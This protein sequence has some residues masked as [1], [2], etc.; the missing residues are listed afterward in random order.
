MAQHAICTIFAKNY[1]SFV[2]VLADS[3]LAHHPHG[4]VYGLLCDR[5]DGYFDPAQ[6]R[7]ITIQLEELS[8]PELPE[9]IYKY[10]LVEL[11]TAVKAALLAYLFAHYS[12]DKL[13][14]FDPDILI[15][16][17]LQEIF[18]LLENHNIVLLPHLTEPQTG[19]WIPSEKQL[20]TLGTYNLG[21]IGLRKGPVTH[22]FLEWW[23]TKLMNDCYVDPARGLYVDQHW[24]DLVP[25]LFEKVYV[26]RDPGCN[27]AYWNLPERPIVR[28]GDT[29]WCQG[30][31]VKF[32]H[33]SGYSPHAP[34]R[35][36]KRVP[37]FGRRLSI[38]TLGAG[39]EL[40]D[41][42]RRLLIQHDFETT[43]RWPY[44]LGSFTNGVPVP[45]AARRLWK[46]ACAAGLHWPDPLDS[47]PPDSFYQW[48]LQPIDNGA[49][50]INRLADYVYRVRL[51]VQKAFP[52]QRG[53][54][55]RE[56]VRWY[57]ETGIQEHQIPE[58]FAQP[59][60]HSLAQTSSTLEKGAFRL[61]P[62]LKRLRAS[63]LGQR[64][65]RSSLAQRARRWLYPAPAVF[66]SAVSGSPPLSSNSHADR[67]P[68]LNVIG[69]LSA[70]TD[71]GAISRGIVHAL[72]AAKYPIAIIHLDHPD[73]ARR[74]DW[75]FLDL[76]QSTR[77]GVNLFGIDAT[78]CGAVT[79]LLSQEVLAHRT[80]IGF[81]LWEVAR[82]PETWQDRFDGLDEIWV[83]SAFVQEA[84]GTVSPIP[85]VKMGAPVV[86]RAPSALSRRDVRLPEDKFVFLYAFDMLSIPERKNPL[87]VVEA[88]RLAFEPNFQDTHLVVRANHL[89]RFPEWQERLRQ[90][91]AS[92]KGTLIEEKLDRPHVNALYHL[93]DAYVSLHR[94]EG[95]GLTIAEM[96]QMGK[97]VIATDYSGPRD[98]LNQSN[99]YPVRYRLIELDRDYGPY[100]AGNV[101]ADPD[102]EHAAE[103]MR[104]ILEHP[105][106][107]ARKAQQAAQDIERLY[108]TSAIA[109]RI[110]RRLDQIGASL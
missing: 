67:Q 91:V 56:F 95:F 46:E 37:E 68:G 12:L 22:R 90:A 21:F 36:S 3:F 73:G 57:V 41:L 32:F 19:E 5:L 20:L 49:P 78:E 74:D 18:D 93:A 31:P 98:F 89:H 34:R 2:R 33:F 15:L 55:R 88:Y 100:R 40:F 66:P 63:R 86:L 42:Y 16:S 29:Y 101:W 109:D 71:V 102:T 77:H 105:E 79:Q 69:H 39:A 13:C 25:G 9:I 104:R 80:N 35:I 103:L 44:A 27:I 24:V 84:V 94:S 61:Q 26:H 4:V 59:M 50:L 75:P 92:V 8:I 64:V 72:R 85:V 47:T 106:D 62:A 60:R 70:E 30:Q 54:H 43:S 108:G 23:N 6:E 51:D 110:I 58:A 14:Y 28:R 38:D 45:Q 7:F 107:R 96:M 17:S 10:D 87:A 83:S 1:L 11:S 48:L 76:P 52:D 81:W 82:F 99:G 97:P 65:A 53:I